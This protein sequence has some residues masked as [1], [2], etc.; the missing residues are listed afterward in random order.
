MPTTNPNPDPH[1]P[2]LLAV[3]DL[4]QWDY[5]PRIVFYAYLM[6][7]PRPITFKME[8]GLAAHDREDKREKRRSTRLYGLPEAERIE[9]VILQSERLGLSGRLSL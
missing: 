1:S 5:C 8:A 3:T 7:D 4:K 9:D 2:W 6:P